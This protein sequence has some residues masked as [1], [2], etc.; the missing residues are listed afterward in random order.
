M[1]ISHITTYLILNYEG[2]TCPSSIHSYI[3]RN[4]IILLEC[5]PFV[6]MEPTVEEETECHVTFKWAVKAA[7][8]NKPQP[9]SPQQCSI[10]FGQNLFD[11]EPLSHFQGSWKM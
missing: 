10:Y 8:V 2:D 3:S 5:S 4:V 1:T 6:D 7:C 11:L 9:V